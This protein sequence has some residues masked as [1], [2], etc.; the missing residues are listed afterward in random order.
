MKITPTK[1]VLKNTEKSDIDLEKVY[2]ELEESEKLLKEVIS[3]IE[4][5][6]RIRQLFDLLF[7][8][9][10]KLTTED[11]FSKEFTDWVSWAYEEERKLKKSLSEEDEMSRSDRL[12]KERI[13]LETKIDELK[14]IIYLNYNEETE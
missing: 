11:P 2:D 8:F 1:E 14:R 3:E 4:G 9:Q 7:H 13:K 5:K 6:D 10:E 12:A